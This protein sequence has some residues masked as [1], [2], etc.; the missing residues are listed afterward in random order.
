MDITGKTILVTGAGSGIERAIAEEV[1]KKIMLEPAAIKREPAEIA[2]F[3][4][5]S[6]RKRLG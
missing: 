4:L 6:A 5:I 2:D 3:T 1:V